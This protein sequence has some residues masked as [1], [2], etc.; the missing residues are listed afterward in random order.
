MTERELTLLREEIRRIDSEI[1]DLVARRQE[2]AAEIGLCKRRQ[3]TPLRD[4]EQEER[5]L[6]RVAS[7][8][9]ELGID[10]D[11]AKDLLRILISHSLRVQGSPE[12][13]RAFLG[14]R[15]LVV[16]GAGRMG[17][18]TCRYLSNRG[19]EVSVWDDRAKL[20]GYRNVE[21]LTG[22][23]AGADIVV[24][25]SPPG[26]C[27]SHLGEVLE[28]APK[29]LVFD[30]CSVK[31]H[32]SGI[33]RESAGRGLKVTSVHPM[34]GPNV[35]SPRGLNVLVCPCGSSDADDEA[36]GL[37][38][39]GGA[40]AT[41]V[42]LD[43]HDRLM[44]YGLGLPHL[45]TL[46]FGSV[47]KGSGIQPAELESTAGPSFSRLFRMASELSSE[48]RRVYHDIQALNPHSEAMLAGF[49]S[50]FRELREAALDRDP[51]A[52][53]KIMESCKE[54]FGG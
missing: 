39:T 44:A 3:D 53:G 32:I 4:N 17:E 41:R 25:S 12:L 23:L 35:P 34:F 22:G 20:P 6:G 9:R 27:A 15:A 48:S 16:G 31:S 50:T 10:E 33:L 26:T 28:T 2:I 29:G 40:V 1:I 49:E 14:K 45:C 52:F 36:E 30:I 51:R 5:V 7:R 54:Y 43:E 42:E 24:V 38:L 21:S 47:V 37:F 19:A 46:L 13:D 8:A 11:L 18:W